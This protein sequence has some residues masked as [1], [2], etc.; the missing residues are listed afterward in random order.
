MLASSARAQHNPNAPRKQM[1][2][3]KV[4]SPSPRQDGRL[5]DP[6]WQKA[7]WVSDFAQ[8]EPVENGTPSGKTEVAIVYDDAAV[9]VGAR[10]YCAHPEKLAGYLDR[11]DT[12]GPAEQFIV[13]FD[14][15][16]DHRTAYGFGVNVAGVRFDRY[17]YADNE[18]SRDFSYNPVWEARTARDAVSWTVE[19]RI[20]FSQLRFNDQP[21]QIWGVQFNRW[22]PERFEDI[23]WV[24][25][26]KNATGF[27][28]WFGE[29]SGIENVKPSRR[30][31]LMPYAASNASVVPR[32]DARDP[33]HD[34]TTLDQRIGGDLKMGLGPNLTVDATINPDFGQVEADPAV[35][36]LSAYESSFSE[37]RPFF[38][39]G[40]DLLH[41]EGPSYFYSRRIG[42][43]PHGRAEGD[44]VK[45]PENNT[46]LGAAKVSGRLNPKTSL[47]MLAAL[48]GREQATSYDS[49]TH[50]TFK[51]VIEPPT[52]YGLAAV[53]QE[54]GTNGSTVGLLLTGMRRDFFT[55]ADLR[56]I[57]R[58]QAVTGNFDWNLRFNQGAYDI[59]GY[60][61]FSHVRGDTAVMRRTQQAPAHYF[62]RP[63]AQAHVRVD[64]TRRAMTGF[65]AQVRGGKRSGK[66]WLWGG[67]ANFETPDFELNDVGILGSADDISHWGHVTYRENTPGRLFHSYW[68]EVDWSSDWNFGGINTGRGIDLY[69]SMTFKNYSSLNMQWTKRPST[70]S[71]DMTRGG[72]LM[73]KLG[74]QWVSLRANSPYGRSTQYGTGMEYD[75][76]EEG[77]WFYGLSLSYSRRI[78]SRVSLSVSPQWQGFRDPQAWY[79]IVDTGGPAATNGV[80]YIFA[81]LRASEVRLGMRLN[82]FFSPVLS[83]EVYAEPFA[84][85]GK[86]T[87]LGELSEPRS[88]RLLTY[89]TDSPGARDYGDRS[90][91]SN[92]VLR[93]EFA[94]GSTMYLVWQRNRGEE[95][96]LGRQVR[97]SSLGDALGASGS[98]YLAFKLSY[99]IPVR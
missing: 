43:P 38:A 45:A 23:F 9:Y 71:D 72:P 26:P 89:T 18:G 50:T 5:D 39:E 63:D 3:L 37:R 44:F 96:E 53:R 10:M 46:I 92:I 87:N 54:F 12:Q 62:Q 80:R 85:G 29:M 67:G 78:G 91:R 95:R 73:R 31:E 51:T 55:T 56:R 86:Y 77:G 83:L 97:L 17:N 27:S 93:W 8:K 36:N 42:G 14:S 84:A 76:S 1:T 7:V 13:T 81:T 69:G 61:G 74:T 25:V 70:L 40:N 90:F 66:H 94:R 35:V 33:L 4:N 52:V 99:W 41:P 21:V 75:W 6:V 49:A 79:G 24:V 19:M 15:Y 22:I 82:Y 11:H 48:T 30:L 59:V 68:A 20:P 16:H 64:P 60:A 88:S 28:S 98:D 34:R 57:L 32:P 58:D 47:S 65:T 2:A